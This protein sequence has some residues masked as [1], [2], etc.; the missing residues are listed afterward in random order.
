M[1]TMPAI[2]QHVTIEH[3]DLQPRCRGLVWTV[4][5]T[6]NRTSDGTPL[7]YLVS[8]DDAREGKG[9]MRRLDSV[10]VEHLRPAPIL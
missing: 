2:G 8:T 4:E 6:R 3:A 1:E 9:H 10:P 7:A 5:W